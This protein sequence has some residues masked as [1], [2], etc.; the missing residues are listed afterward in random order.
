[1]ILDFSLTLLF[2]HLVLTTYY[3]A[4]IPTSI[5][6]WLVMAGGAA[7]KITVAEQLC[8][9]REMN[10]GLSVNAP[11]VEEDVEMGRLLGE[12][13]ERNRDRRRD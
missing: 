3:S 2:N 7:L 5:F 13:A 9:K 11:Q 12:E 10:E 8:I 1:M 6:F 4:S